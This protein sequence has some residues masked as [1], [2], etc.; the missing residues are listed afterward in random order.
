VAQNVSN[1]RPLRFHWRLLQGGERT[2]LPRATQVRLQQTGLP[3]LDAQI[4]FCRRAEESGIDALLTDIGATK[5]DPIILA[6][7]LGLATGKIEFLIAYRS[8]MMS[9][10]TFVQQLNTL[11]AMLPGRIL[12]NIV[13]GHSPAEQR[14]YG[15]FLPHDERYERT[16]EF[17]SICHAFWRRDGDVDFKGR[18][19]TIER[20]ALNTPF[21]SNRRSPEIFIAGGSPAAQRLAIDVGTLWMRFADTPEKIRESAEPMLERRVEVGLRMAIVARPTR[22]EA[23]RAARALVEEIDG[24]RRDREN[25]S[26]FVMRSDS[27]SMR[28]TYTLAEKEWLNDWLWTG[29]VRLYGAPGVAIVGSPEEVASAIMEYKRAGVSQFIFSGWPKE[30]EMIFFGR[31]I[32]PLVRKMEQEEA[33]LPRG[34]RGGDATREA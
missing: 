2:S 18:H 13:A 31:N 9:P 24:T 3:E 7:A 16:H 12:L 11:S 19:Y 10:T 32:V 6:T 1:V 29:A 15:D 26:Q 33:A 25:E 20:G 5:P 34:S 30:E 23:L 28:A 21:I 22:G 8:G 17:L 14:F 4:D 27:I